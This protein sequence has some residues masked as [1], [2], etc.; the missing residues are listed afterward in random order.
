MLGEWGGAATGKDAVLSWWLQ[1]V[2]GWGGMSVVTWSGCELWGERMGVP[3]HSL[4]LRS[5]VKLLNILEFQP[6]G[7][8]NE[9]NPT[10]LAGWL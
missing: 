8:E 2:V 1:G 10:S 9:G 4:P 3:I 7:V 6:L 5:F